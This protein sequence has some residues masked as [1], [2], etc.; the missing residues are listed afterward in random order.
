MFKV[1]TQPHQT[2]LLNVNLI[3]YVKN[4]TVSNF[5]QRKNL[6]LKEITFKNVLNN[7]LMLAI[8]RSE[9]TDIRKLSGRHKIEKE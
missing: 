5:A 8:P 7:F 4:I 2:K 9:E 1:S 6:N 3:C